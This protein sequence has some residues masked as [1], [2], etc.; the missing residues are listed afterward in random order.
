MP[1]PLAIVTENLDEAPEAW[2]SSRCRVE[3]AETDSPRFGDLAAEAEALVVRTYTRVDSM[4]LDRLPR[5]R[6]VG[7]AGVGLD[8][9]DLTE[10]RRRGVAVVH[11]PE[12]NTQAVVEYVTALLCDALRPRLV[13]P[14]PV[15][16]DRWHDLRREVVADRQMDTLSLGILGFGRIGRRVAEVARAIGFRVR[17]ND[18]LP[19]PEELRRLAEPVE[20]ESLFAESDVISLHIDG[21]PSN[22]GVVDRRLLSLLKPNVTV[23]NTC[24]GMVLDHDALGA[25][26][27]EHPGSQALLDVHEPEPPPPDHPL[28]NLP[29]AHLLPHL[30]SRTRQATENMSWVVKDVVAVLEG[31]R[32]RWPANEPGETER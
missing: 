29:N 31:R 8:N 14:G 22:R 16:I 10:C 11:T 12:A 17:A 5:L 7:R 19:M 23:L 30:A 15:S 3:R 2:L 24:R 21:R 1:I 4:L 25:H 18:L 32:P 20:V 13:L 9:I 27:R 26:L 6:V 28:W